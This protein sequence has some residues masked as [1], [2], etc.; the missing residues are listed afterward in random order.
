[1]FA[2]IQSTGMSRLNILCLFSVFIPTDMVEKGSVKS[3]EVK[4]GILL[5]ESREPLLGKVQ[6]LNLVM[7]LN[8]R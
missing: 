2:Y 1:M 4:S 6:Y 7:T 5:T 3:D 8:K